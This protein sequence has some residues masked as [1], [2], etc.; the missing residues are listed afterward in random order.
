MI[1]IGFL[2]NIGSAS[3]VNWTGLR[4]QLGVHLV[5]SRLG[6]VVAVL[7]FHCDMQMQM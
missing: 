3:G 5:Q 2:R 1:A 6:H 7:A 4:G